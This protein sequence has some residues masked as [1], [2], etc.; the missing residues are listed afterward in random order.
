MNR[1]CRMT[2]FKYFNSENKYKIYENGSIFSIKT[3]KFLTTYYSNITKC[4]NISL[5]VNGKNKKFIV[6]T[7]IYN[8]FNEN[9]KK[10]CYI[11]HIDNNLRNNN[12]DNLVLVSRNKNIV[13]LETN[14]I[15]WVEIPLYENRYVINKEG[16]IKS[17][18]INKFLTENTSQKYDTYKTIKLVDKNGKRKSYYIHR[19]VYKSFVGEI[20][21]N[22]IIDHINQNKHDNRLD[23]LRM[24][25]QGDNVKNCVKIF[26]NIVLNETNDKFISISTKYKNYDF[27]NYKINENGEIKN[28]NEKILKTTK[29][30]GYLFCY[31]YDKLTNKKITMSIHQLVATIFLLN[32]D[33]YTLVH[34]KDNN[35]ENNN[36]KNLEW[37]THKQNIT[38][39]QGKKIG[40]YNINNELI[41]FFDSVND[42]FRELNKTYGNNIRLVCEGKRKTAFGYKWKWV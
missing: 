30:S 10:G 39:T 15:E 3:N 4:E 36:Y 8:A 22:M 13:E 34:H 29:K 18:L 33:N 27:S 23:N 2:T 5:V 38:Y 28:K 25:T 17:L 14:S 11:K 7:L 20:N 9:V 26:S 31:L 42:A 40:Q 16:I 35:R 37:T 6:H 21:E 1:P 19:L 32:I 24:I 41:K 12:I